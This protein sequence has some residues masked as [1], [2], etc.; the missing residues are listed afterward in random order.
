MVLSPVITINIFQK[1]AEPQIYSAGQVIFEEGQSG[2]V[3]FGIIEGEVEISALHNC[4][5]K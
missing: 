1:Q 2:D 3:M 5:M 4:G